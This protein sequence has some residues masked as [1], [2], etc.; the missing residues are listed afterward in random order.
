MGLVLVALSVP[1]A[2]NI[3]ASRQQAMFL[4]RLQDATRFAGAA[5]QVG[6]EVDQRALDADLRRYGEL[7]SIAVVELDRSRTV[8]AGAA[9]PLQLDRDVVARAVTQALAG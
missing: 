6:N 8:R 5:E 1:L 7:Y 2:Q 4:D 9:G 3:A